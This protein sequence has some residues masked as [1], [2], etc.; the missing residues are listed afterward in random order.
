MIQPENRVRERMAGPAPRTARPAPGGGPARARRDLASV[1]YEEGA[2]RL[3]PRPKPTPQPED[4]GAAKT[5]NMQRAGSEESRQDLPPE[6]RKRLEAKGYILYPVNSLDVLNAKAKESPDASLSRQKVGPDG[7]RAVTS[8]T[9]YASGEPVGAVMRDGKLDTP[10][11]DKARNRGG[12]AVL[13]DGSIVVGRMRGNTSKE[14]Q[15]AFGEKGNPVRDFMGGGALLVEDG[16]KVASEDLKNRQRF[17]QGGGGLDA[18]Q[19]RKT[20]HVVGAVR[21]GRFFLVVAKNKTGREIQ[22]DLAGAGFSA[23]VKLDGGSGAYARDSR[24]VRTGGHNPTG[25]GVR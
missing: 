21:E 1:G 13:Q 2:A 6:V 15:D 12:I 5:L 25:F 17:D 10:G 16:R 7:Y 23:V 24:G 8:G 11:V 4:T 9:F 22:N 3:S 18:Q 20:D 14:I 19:M